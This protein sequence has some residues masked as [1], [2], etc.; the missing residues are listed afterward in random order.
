MFRSTKALM[1][2]ERITMKSAFRTK[3]LL[4]TS[5]VLP[6]VAICPTGNAAVKSALFTK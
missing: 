3:P 2:P 6:T 4:S 5:R 1:I